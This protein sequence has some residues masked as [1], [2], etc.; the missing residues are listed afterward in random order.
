MN[1]E[2]GRPSRIKIINFILRNSETALFVVS[3]FLQFWYLRIY[4]SASILYRRKSPV[5]LVPW[6]P[7]FNPPSF[8]NRLLLSIAFANST[9]VISL[10]SFISDIDPFSYG[11]L[12]LLSYFPD[13]G[14]NWRKSVIL[15]IFSSVVAL[16]LL[17]IFVLCVMLSKVVFLRCF[18]WLIVVTVWVY[19]TIF[20]SASLSLSNCFFSFVIYSLSIFFI[21]FYSKFD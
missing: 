17:N 15:F 13:E 19:H 4:S 7:Y 12:F 10:S 8:R 6:R 21:V 16:L 14:N 18:R 2:F 11:F 9:D 5:E 1:A 3:Y 20:R